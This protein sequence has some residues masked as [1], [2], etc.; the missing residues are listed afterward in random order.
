MR[1]EL[2]EITVLV[3]KSTHYYLELV[4][5]KQL[6]SFQTF[7]LVNAVY[8]WPLC[9]STAFSLVYCESLLI[10]MF[11]HAMMSNCQGSSLLL[12]L[13]PSSSPFFLLSSFP[14][15]QGKKRKYFEE[16]QGFKPLDDLNC[17]DVISNP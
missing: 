11:L 7:H 2:S 14:T 1:P 3:S 15:F 6:S 4:K 13:S 5:H 9:L 16:H 10:Q 17:L 8:H 12:S